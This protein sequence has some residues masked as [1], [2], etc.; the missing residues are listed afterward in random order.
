MDS[1]KKE[2][3]SELLVSWSKWLISINF[4]SATGC[5]VALKS[6]GDSVQ[7]VGPFFF[8]A[9]LCFSVSV[10][11]STLFVL[12]MAKQKLR[13]SERPSPSY[14]WLAQLQWGLFSAGLIFVLGWIAILSKLI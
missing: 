1:E 3:A 9:V 8:A 11:C 7:K 13:D 4:L 5:I 6:A 10:L 14:I 2:K 12:L